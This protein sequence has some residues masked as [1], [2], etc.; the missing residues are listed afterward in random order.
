MCAPQVTDTNV[1]I[2]RV[3]PKYH[4]YTTAEVEELISRL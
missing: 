4:L 2:A 3:S 1:D